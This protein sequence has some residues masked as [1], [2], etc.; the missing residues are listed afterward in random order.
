MRKEKGG[1]AIINPSHNWEM[2]KIEKMKIEILVVVY[3]KKKPSL[4]FF[5]HKTLA[6]ILFSL[7]VEEKF[8]RTL[9]RRDFE[10]KKER[11][12]KKEEKGSP[13]LDFISLN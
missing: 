7:M 2:E 6:S 13:F 10:R 9:L 5:P 11:R 3:K 4:P 1:G 12:R 8:Y